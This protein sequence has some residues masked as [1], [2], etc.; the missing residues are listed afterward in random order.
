[1]TDD[2]LID[3][4]QDAYPRI[5]SACHI[6]HRTRARPS[7]AGLTDRE[8]GL[9]MHVPSGGISPT[10][11]TAHLGIAKSTLSAHLTRLQSLGLVQ[12]NALDGDQRR[13]VVTLTAEGRMA[14]RAD[15]VLDHE[16]LAQL[17]ATIPSAERE[18][19]VRGLA[20]LGE[21]ACN[22]RMGH[23]ESA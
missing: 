1:M 22:V 7:A 12:V 3:L 13:R 10:E 18:A 8:A 20:R 5:W 9:L 21:A 15:A 4:I 6:E 2:E 11:L 14:R 16:R 23:E 19:A 17:L